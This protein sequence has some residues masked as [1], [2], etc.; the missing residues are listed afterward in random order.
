MDLKGHDSGMATR[1]RRAKPKGSAY[2]SGSHPLTPLQP[3]V[4]HGLRQKKEE[5][6]GREEP[7]CPLL[8]YSSLSRRQVGDHSAARMYLATSARAMRPTEERRGFLLP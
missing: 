3:P 7:A 1:V 6:K 5:E 2:M 4:T 8:P